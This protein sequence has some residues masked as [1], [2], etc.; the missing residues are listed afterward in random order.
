M[1][2]EGYRGRTWSRL[3]SAN[4][5]SGD[6]QQQARAACSEL[7]G[8]SHSSLVSACYDLMPH[9]A[10]VLHSFSESASTTDVTLIDRTWIRAKEALC[11]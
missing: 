9:S 7:R 8:D 5:G 11:S 4:E 2:R 1:G 6:E 3:L 10:I